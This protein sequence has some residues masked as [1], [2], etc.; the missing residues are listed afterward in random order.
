MK[1]TDLFLGGG[2]KYPS[3]VQ[4]SLCWVSVFLA[5]TT[6]TPRFGYSVLANRVSVKGWSAHPALRSA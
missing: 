4:T 5:R 3:P 2:D 6:T 1:V